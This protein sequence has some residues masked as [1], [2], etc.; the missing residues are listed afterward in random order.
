[1]NECMGTGKPLISIVVPVY[2]VESY[3]RQCIESLLNQTYRYLDIIL[4]DDGSLDTSGMICDEYAAAD[5]RIT[6]MHQSNQGVSAARNQGVQTA[7]GEYIAFVDADDWLTPDYLACL[8]SAMSK[9]GADIVVALENQETDI[10]YWSGTEALETM[11]YQEKFDTSPWGKLFRAEVAKAVPVPA[12][13]FFEDLA[14]VCRMIGMAAI[15]TAVYCSGYC[16]RKNPT[17]TMHGGSSSRLLDELKAADMMY[18]Y[19]VE[20]LDSPKAARCRKFS[21]YCQVLLK[22]PKSGFESEKR[23]IWQYIR[24]SRK[25]VLFDSNARLKNRAAAF[26][27]IFGEKL[28]RLL[29][30]MS[31]KER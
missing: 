23:H 9:S 15:V 10:C 11:L 16:Y 18:R 8:Q 24:T 29:W 5:K 27:S 31:Q 2:N 3:I 17:G 28:M 30:K 22:L 1:M 6:V 12:G 13:M 19:A 21:S 14:V 25:Y 4:V 20:A 7:K 26:A